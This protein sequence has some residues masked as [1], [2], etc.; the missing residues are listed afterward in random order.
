MYTSHKIKEYIVLMRI[1][2][3]GFIAII[4]VIGAL[5]ADP[6]INGIHLLKLFTVGIF[7]HV[8]AYVLNE[9][10]D[11]EIDKHSQY[12]KDKPLVSGV[13]PKHHALIIVFMAVMIS[14]CL[15]ALYFDLLSVILLLITIGFVTL[16]DLTNKKMKLNEFF[17][18]L[19]VLSFCLFGAVS[20]NNDIYN[21]SFLTWMMGIAFFLRFLSGAIACGV[22]LKDIK[23]DIKNK[24]VTIP[25][26]LGVHINDNKIKMPMI[27][28]FFTYLVELSS[29]SLFFIIFMFSANYQEFWT[30]GIV[31]L[32]MAG[33][34]IHLFH[35]FHTKA[36]KIYTRRKLLKIGKINVVLGYT[37]FPIVLIPHIGFTLALIILVIPIAWA[38]IIRH[39]VY[40]ERVY[41]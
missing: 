12:L 28:K 39:T 27:Y 35:F 16:Y 9:W 6:S 19:G 21:I 1:Y 25:I 7:M 23:N 2:F 40:G 24:A 10:V 11:L 20:S 32:I 36:F 4:P 37:L 13:I 29:I 30:V 17:Q 34:T 31:L 18:S 8:Y 15:T 26:L 5:S 3:V 14:I 41:H 38:L 33:L 22:G